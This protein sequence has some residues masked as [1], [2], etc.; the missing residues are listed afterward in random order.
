MTKRARS[1]LRL[2]QGT[3]GFYLDE[4]YRHRRLTA[5]IED[6]LYRWGYLP[7]QTP[8]FDFFDPYEPL[9]HGDEVRDVYR[10]IDREGDLLMLRSD[11]TLF[12]A[13]QMG[14]ILSE[15]EL[16]V[17]ACYFDTILRHQNAEDISK[18]EFFQIGA[19]LIGK[20]GENGDMEVMLLL[21]E[22]LDAVP[23][24]SYR[25]HLGSRA[26]F[27]ALFGGFPANERQRLARAIAMRDFQLVHSILEASGGASKRAAYLKQI[28]R[29][30]GDWEELERTMS[31]GAREGYL[32]DSAMAA[33]A[34]LGRIWKTLDSLG[35]AE[36]YRIDLSEVGRHP[37][38]TGIVFQVYVDGADS[39]VATGGRY[40]NLLSNFGFN[41]A[42]VGFSLMLR[43]VEAMMPHPESYG[44]PEKVDR[45]NEADFA[46]AYRRATKIR[47]SGRNAIIC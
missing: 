47:K 6:L 1:L 36:R 22:I 31:I 25:F 45:V 19:E 30:I 9:F 44:P 12:L 37:Y 33:A 39:S 42:S 10:L 38:Y 35:V 41:A 28:F 11:I 15:Q 26:F 16:P 23:L 34:D 20:P 2:P 24:E 21:S 17:R 32:D 4:A 14:M 13:R 40:D 27:D 43:K 5:K 46:S 18:N 3:E 29:F 7:V 8:V